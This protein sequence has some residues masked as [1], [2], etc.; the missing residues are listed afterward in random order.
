MCW[1]GAKVVD[2]CALIQLALIEFSVRFM[3]ACRQAQWGHC[4]PTGR[5]IG[6]TVPAGK[7]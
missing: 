1:F 6:G 3:G 4:A 5:L 7:C 2:A